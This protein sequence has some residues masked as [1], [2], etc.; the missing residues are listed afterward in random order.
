M[1]ARPFLF[2][3]FAALGLVSCA[4]SEADE[5]KGGSQ[6]LGGYELAQG[7]SGNGAKLVTA[8]MNRA[9]D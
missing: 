5:D 2:Y 8:S 7:H 4:P 6:P 3:P 9:S 1:L